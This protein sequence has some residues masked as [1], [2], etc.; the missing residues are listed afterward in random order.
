MNRLALDDP[1]ALDASPAVPKLLG[2]L[3][4]CAVREGAGHMRIC[5]S[6]TEAE[7][8]CR[9]P[10]GEIEMVP[11]PPDRV[12]ELARA[13]EGLAPQ[14]VLRV[15][16]DR[17][18]LPLRCQVRRGNGDVSVDLEWEAS[19]GQVRRAGSVLKRLFRA[20]LARYGAVAEE[21]L[22]D[23]MAGEMVAEVEGRE[24]TRG[25]EGRLS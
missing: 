18:P 16:L 21:E 23:R 8:R 10:S 9:L 14:G 13:V 3:L 22:A 4:L 5:R 17:A 2:M 15:E 11:P 7:V 1:Q 6:G 19:A 25:N 20:Q 12:D 24:N